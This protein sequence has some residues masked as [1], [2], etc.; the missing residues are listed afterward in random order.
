MKSVKLE[1]DNVLE[2]NFVKIVFT[3]LYSKRFRGE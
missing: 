1:F 2:N 3:Y